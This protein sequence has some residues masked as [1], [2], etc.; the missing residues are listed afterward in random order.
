VPSSLMLGTTVYITTDIAAIPLL[1]VLPLELYLLSFILVFSKLPAWLDK[2]IVV[3]FLGGVLYYLST[4]LPTGQVHF[5]P[6]ELTHDQA[7]WALYA[8]ILPAL[9]LLWPGIPPLL[10][11]TMVL[12]LPMAVLIIA[13]LTLAD[14]K[15]GNVVTSIL[16]HLV[17]L[18]VVAMVCHGELARDRPATEYLTGF[19]LWMSL[20][21]VLGGMFNALAAPLLFTQVAEYP[22]AM[23]MACLLFPGFGQESK[24]SKGGFWVDTALALAPGIL[25]IALLVMAYRGGKTDLTVESVEGLVQADPVR[26][27]VIGGVGLAAALAIIFARKQGRGLRALDIGAAVALGL[28]TA[29][30][31]LAIPVS[32]L[33]LDNIAD[34][35]HLRVSMVRTIVMYVLPI[36]LC[37]TFLTR[38]I[39]FGLSVGAVLLAGTLCESLDSNAVYRDRS[40]FGVLTV[41]HYKSDNSNQLI[42]GTT[43]HGKQYLDEDKRRTA[44]TYYHETG[45]IGQVFTDVIQPDKKKEIAL[46]GLGTGTLASYGEKG[47][48]L[49]FYD[50][51]KSVVRISRDSGLFSYYKDSEARGTDL[52]IKL[53]DARLKIE[54]ARDGQYDLIVVD[55]FSSDAIPVH[56]ITREAL[57]L[58]RQ[59]L[60]PGGIVAFHT[61][62]RYLKL[63]PVVA[64]TAH[65]LGMVAIERHDDSEAAA[66]KTA[67][68]WVLVARN[69]ADFGKI[70]DDCNVRIRLDDA[71]RRL[72]ELPDKQCSRIIL[73]VRRAVE[74]VNQAWVDLLRPKL[75]PGGVLAFRVYPPADNKEPTLA[76][77]AAAQLKPAGVVEVEPQSS[78]DPTPDWV[79]VLVADKEDDTKELRGTI[80]EGTGSTRRWDLLF[81]DPGKSTWTDDFSNLLSVFQWR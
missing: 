68:T 2:A 9:A 5:G 26:L 44:L 71:K 49:T 34:T 27:A 73:D 36:L 65:D 66:G 31:I 58:Y 39:R 10:H 75:R 4:I 60:A 64:N 72:E 14:M 24:S 38:P 45:P 43:L 76:K 57:D 52:E 23:V 67:S 11:K 28:L 69:V 53:G 8:L 51:D 70:W 22:L 3:A 25:G 32:E 21:G 46:I 1:W 30:L 55:A 48:H 35:L 59:K 56:L 40:F 62:N 29:G 42:H 6:L 77:A 16:L 20:G 17:V 18:F 7:K 78:E 54:G 33:N 74:E 19:Y 63:E 79:W 47:M 50:I 37:V 13:F 81:S 41:K 15:P 80:K 61:S 12:L